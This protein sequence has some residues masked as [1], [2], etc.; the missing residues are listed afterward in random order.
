MLVIG[1]IMFGF[2]AVLAVAILAHRGRMISLRQTVDNT[3][4]GHSSSEFLETLEI[5]C[6]IAANEIHDTGWHER[7]T[8]NVGKSPLLWRTLG[9]GTS[10]LPAYR[11]RRFVLPR[12]LL[13]DGPTASSRQQI[14]LV[15]I[16]R[17]VEEGTNPLLEY[18]AFFDPPISS[19]DARKWRVEFSWPQFSN[20]FRRTGC[21]YYEAAFSSRTTE[22]TFVVSAPWPL[23]SKFV[24][25]DTRNTIVTGVG[26]REVCCSQKFRGAAPASARR[27]FRVE[28]ERLT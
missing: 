2:C 20:L 21:D 8:C 22:V 27:R 18:A 17:P 12:A 6:R 24:Q 15:P 11:Y 16:G 5:G 4:R 25:S 7:E 3:V 19:G 23:V 28:Y 14:Y 1:A 9:I 10:D 13:I 26:G